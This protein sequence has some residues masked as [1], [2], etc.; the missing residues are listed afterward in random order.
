MIL[1]LLASAMVGI[2]VATCGPIGFVGI[3]VPH[4]CRLILGHSHV[5]LVPASLVVGG[6]F[7]TICDTV[8]RTITAP[9]EIPVGVF[10]ALL[11]GPFF[12]W[13][14]FW[15]RRQFAM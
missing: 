2:V 12:L 8:A 1:F 13:V 3:I 15:Q 9:F 4:L 5:Y 11:G 6:S 14:L 10:T 7:L